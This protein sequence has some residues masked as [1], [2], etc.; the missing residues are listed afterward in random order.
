MLTDGQISGIIEHMNDAHADT[1]LLYARVIGNRPDTVEAKM[2][3]IDRHRM[4][5]EIQAPSRSIEPLNILLAQA[6][7][8]PMDA[9]RV[10]VRMAKRARQQTLA[11]F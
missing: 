8:T 6:I 10:L 7:S 4:T 11:S 2:T 3:S 5:L 9:R 1:V